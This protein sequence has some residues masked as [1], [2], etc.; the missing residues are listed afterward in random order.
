MWAL[1]VKQLQ[2]TFGELRWTTRSIKFAHCA[3]M[4]KNPCN[5]DFRN[6]AMH[7]GLGNTHKTLWVN[8]PMVINHHGWLPPPPPPHWKQCVFVTKS[9]RQVQHVG[10]IWSLLK[11][12]T[13]Q[14]LWIEWNDL[15]FNNEKWNVG[16]IHKIIWDALLDYGRVV[17]NRCMWLLK[18]PLPGEK[19]TS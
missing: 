18:K 13:L 17:W 10:A 16:K 12:I 15:V 3:I 5:I 19:K 1:G 2:L 9:P 8:F 11:G 7:N 4:K 14:I 6:V